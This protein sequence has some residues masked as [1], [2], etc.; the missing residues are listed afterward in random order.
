MGPDIYSQRYKFPVANP[1]GV[2]LFFRSLFLRCIFTSDFGNSPFRE[3]G[4]G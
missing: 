2:S 1:L 3:F 4:W